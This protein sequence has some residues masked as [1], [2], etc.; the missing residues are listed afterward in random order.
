M[1]NRTDRRSD[2]QQPMVGKIEL[3]GP[4]LAPISPILVALC[5]IAV[6]G[7]GEGGTLPFIWCILVTTV[8]SKARTAAELHGPLVCHVAMVGILHG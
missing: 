2:S 8:A 5:L 4:I 1:L 7:W 6:L 3:Q